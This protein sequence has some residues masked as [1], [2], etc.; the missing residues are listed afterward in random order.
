[1]G[2]ASDPNPHLPIQW[3][4]L[5]HKSFISPLLRNLGQLRPLFSM[6]ASQNQLIG[7]HQITVR[8]TTTTL[9]TAIMIAT[10]TLRCRKLSLRWN[11]VTGERDEGWRKNLSS[12]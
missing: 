8:R 10:P 7:S 11:Q 5:S 6:S 3:Q 4:D 1:M 9:T 12:S 2:G